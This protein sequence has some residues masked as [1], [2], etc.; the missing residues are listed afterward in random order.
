NA[1]TRS[2][3]PDQYHWQILDLSDSSIVID[4]TVAGTQAD[5]SYTLL[6]DTRIRKKYSVKLL[7]EKS[8]LCFSQTEKIV[9]VNPVPEADITYEML[10]AD[11]ESVVYKLT[12][13]GEGLLYDWQITRNP[14]NSP[15]LTERSIE[16]YYNKST[17]ATY[18]VKV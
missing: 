1:S 7:A 5:F 12:A 17:S 9:D 18:N 3:N 4:S 8:G 2:L 10:E 15:D 14:L 16:L 13:Q 11:G 6:N